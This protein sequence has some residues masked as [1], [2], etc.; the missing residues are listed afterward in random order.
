MESKRKQLEILRSSLELERS[1]FIS[2]WQDL[3]D[4]FLPYKSRF[5]TTDANR[6][7]RRNHNI[8][9]SSG[10]FAAKT[11]AAGMQGGVTSPARPWFNLGVADQDMMEY[12]PVKEWCEQVTK[13]MTF[14][15]NKSNLYKCLP[16]TYSSM[17]VFATGAMSFEESFDRMFRFFA[18]PIG[19]YMISN[20]ENLQV[21]TFIREFRMTVRQLIAM[22]G[23]K[24]NQGKPDWSVFSTNV[25]RLWETGQTEQWVDVVHC[26][27]PNEN[28]D[29]RKLESKYKRYLSCYYE[30]GSMGGSGSNYLV[31][32]D[33]ERMLRESGYDYFPILVPRWETNGEDAWGTDSPGMIAIG[34]NKQLQFGEKRAA[35]GIDK[36]LRPPMKGDPSL[37][38]SKTTQLPGDVTFVD[39][40][41]GPGFTPAFTVD[42]QLMALEN[43]QAQVRSRMDRA[44]YVD[45]FLQ[46]SRTD[47]RSITAREIEERHE[48]KLIALGP[49]LEQINQDLLD[50]MIEIAFNIM[51]SRPGL[52]PPI[53]DEMRGIDLSIEYIS[54]MAQAQK[55]VGIASIER[56]IQFTGSVAAM[57]PRVMDKVDFDQVVDDYGGRVGISAK[58]IRSDDDVAKRREAAAKAAQQARAPEAISTMAGAAADLASADMEGDNAL[59]RIIQGGQKNLSSAG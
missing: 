8:V 32:S 40:R 47:R 49:V 48:E 21:D 19:S 46:L 55:L 25:R 38:T 59:T 37:K 36:M 45:L 50:P 44:F 1:S 13:M 11:L 29:R 35:E 56:F 26:V 58:I 53:P 41:Q 34:D 23:R 54:L 22:F 16:T 39:M 18:F 4:Y 43:K 12:Q 7:D 5:R 52:L 30:K 9:D 15:F 3:S 28:Y 2:Q 20:N 33:D 27:K 17:G 6:G 24:D 51:L 57:D 31:S 42:P 14:F 10:T